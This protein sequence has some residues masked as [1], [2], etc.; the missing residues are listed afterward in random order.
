M[1]IGNS[2]FMEYKK[3]EDGSFEKLAQR[4]VDFGGGLE[5][6]TAAVNKDADVFKINTLFAVITKIEELSSKK[7]EDNITSFRVVADHIRGAAFMIGDSVLPSNT[8]RGYFVRRLVRRA[9][10]HA[11]IIEMKEGA[12]ALLVE[13]LIAAYEGSYLELEDQK[14]LFYYLTYRSVNKPRIGL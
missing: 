12:L 1:E 13:P 4:N 5:R 10:R 14:F 9:V 6:I 11:D 2:V 8:E 7:Y 3:K